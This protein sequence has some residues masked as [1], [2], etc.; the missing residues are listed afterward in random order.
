MDG[1]GVGAMFR[2]GCHGPKRGDGSLRQ[3]FPSRGGAASCGA[4]PSAL[5]GIDALA[6]GVMQ[7]ALFVLKLIPERNRLICVEPG[8]REQLK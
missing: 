6:G 4:A 5:S 2:S 1:E 3:V 7:I 8:K